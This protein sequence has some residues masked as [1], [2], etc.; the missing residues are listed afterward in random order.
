MGLKLKSKFSQNQHVQ[1]STSGF[2]IS[3]E[4]GDIRTEK[5]NV[6]MTGMLQFVI[7]NP[8]WLGEIFYNFPGK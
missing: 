2:Y 8:R 3:F 1:L 5:K 7:C 6:F 4:V